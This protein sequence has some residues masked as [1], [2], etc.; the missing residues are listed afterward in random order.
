MPPAY[1]TETRG[2]TFCFPAEKV[3]GILDE[4]AEVKAERRDIVDVGLQ[5]KFLIKDGGAWPERFYLARKGQLVTDIP[6]S[7]ETGATP[8]FI[9]AVRATPDTDICVDDPTRADRPQ[10]DEGLYFEMGLSP[11]FHNQSGTH[12][13]AELKEG[14]KDGKKFYKKMIPGAFR[15]FMPDTD[16]FA[17]KYKDTTTTPAAFAQTA[18]GEVQLEAE[19]HKDFWVVSLDDMKDIDATTMVVRGGLYELQPVPSPETMRRFGWGQKEDDN[20]K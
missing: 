2:T 19:A 12:S 16:Y 20:A 4:L 5:P 13:L 1:A 7:K 3:P 15:M 10:D 9:S 14:A 17:I 6:F 8:T 11:I 18:S